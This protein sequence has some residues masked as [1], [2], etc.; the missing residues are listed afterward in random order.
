YL[1]KEDRLRASA[2][3]D[4]VGNHC[5]SKVECLAYCGFKD[6]NRAAGQFCIESQ[7][8]AAQRGNI[9]KGLFFRGSESLPFG[10]E[11]RSVLDLLKRLLTEPREIAV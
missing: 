2:C 6:G 3:P 8:A 7:L 9:D 10:C 11:I 1:A 4:P 5:P